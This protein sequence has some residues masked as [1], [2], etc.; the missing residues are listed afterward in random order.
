MVVFLKP[1]LGNRFTDKT[2]VE[3]DKGYLQLVI[4]VDLAHRT[5]MMVGNHQIVRLLQLKDFV[6]L[7]GI[8]Q[9]VAAHHI[10]ILA[11]K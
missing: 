2:A 10:L 5:D 7:A 3:V 4:L 8:Y 9:P 6:Y 11:D 1:A